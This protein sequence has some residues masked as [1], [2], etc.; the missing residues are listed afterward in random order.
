M[1]TSRT[2]VV[3]TLF[4]AALSLAAAAC[5]IFWRGTGP[6]FDF[7]TL[8]G[9]TVAIQGSGLY[10]FDTV[11]MASQA[12]S[13]DIVTLLVGI[14]LLLIALFLYA[15]GSLRGRL[16]LSGTLA[17]FLYTYTSYAFTAAYNELFL[18]YIVLFSA[19]L[20]AFILTLL[21]IPVA[22]LPAHFSR[23]LPVRFI[24]GF[25]I[26]LGA[27][28]VLLWLGRIV[29]PLLDGTAPSALESYTTLVIQALDLGVIVPV[30]F[31]AG[32]LLLKRH[33]LGYLLASLT[34]IK[35]FTMSA[36]LTA[37]IIGQLL[38]GVPL[39]LIEIVLFPALNVVAIIATALLLLNL[40]E[41]S[42]LPQATRGYKAAYP[43]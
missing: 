33:A 12:I 25:A 11:A 17:Y 8:R 9:Q 29:P 39:A 7:Q 23:R 19:S 30:A 10:R 14:P 13:Q 18:V 21:S 20:F 26:F 43:G 24:A 36:A 31:L 38:A 6:S 28:L 16:L 22:D 15:R 4:V 41:S 32:I 37:M 42:S 3:I 40:S 27:M 5:G 1:K 34:L 2:V 35:S